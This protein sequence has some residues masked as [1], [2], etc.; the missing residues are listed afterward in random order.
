MKKLE[1]GGPSR[2]K[3]RV[4]NRQRIFILLLT[5]CTVVGLHL[6]WTLQ[7]NVSSVVSGEPLLIYQQYH[8]VVAHSHLYNGTLLYRAINQAEGCLRPNSGDLDAVPLLEI[9]TDSY[10]QNLIC[11]YTGILA[12]AAHAKA[13]HP[14]P[15][16]GFQSWRAAQKGFALQPRAEASLLSAI[17]SRAH[18]DALYF[19]SDGGFPGEHIRDFYGHCNFIH[20]HCSKV[21][22]DVT[23][24]VLGRHSADP[25]AY[26]GAPPMPLDGGTFAFMSYFVLPTESLVE[27]ARF[28]KAA[29]V[30]LDDSYYYPHKDGGFCIM[31]HGGGGADA[32]YESSHCYCY[33]LE[34]LINVWAYHSG[35][36]MIYVD[37]ATGDME[38]QHPLHNRTMWRQWFQPP[39]YKESLDKFEAVHY[40]NGDGRNLLWRL[41]NQQNRQ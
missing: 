40:Q 4:S 33:I 37:A 1:G 28:A 5:L 21:F 11:E 38:E 6:S 32:A 23:D 22:A 18:G 35:R 19:W 27:Y 26:S 15:W 29:I 16:V 30:A 12:V 2:H 14:R 36:R 9:N 24:D 39:H 17:S 31:A 41:S 7:E 20:E 8:S 25:A 10:Y 34:R 3:R 13:L